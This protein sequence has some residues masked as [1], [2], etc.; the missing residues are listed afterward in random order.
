MA[1]IKS[2]IVITNV[3][4]ATEVVAGTSSLPAMLVRYSSKIMIPAVHQALTGSYSLLA[5]VTEK[6]GIMRIKCKKSN[7]QSK[8]PPVFVSKL[9]RERG[10]KTKK[11]EIS[12]AQE[13]TYL[14]LEI[15]CFSA[16]FFF[17]HPWYLPFL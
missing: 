8:Q 17:L 14:F 4:G 11:R 7:A 1:A 6:C 9:T 16:T 10:G 12:R 5:V 13:K 3:V 2:M 15:G